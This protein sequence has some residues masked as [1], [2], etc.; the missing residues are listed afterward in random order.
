N[1]TIIVQALNRTILTVFNYTAEPFVPSGVIVTSD[2]RV[3]VSNIGNPYTGI[4]IFSLSGVLLSVIAPPS[5]GLNPWGLAYSPVN[6]TLLYEFDVSNNR[7]LTF[8][9]PAAAPASSARGDPQFIGLRGQSFQVHGIDRA[10]YAL[11]SEEHTA[12]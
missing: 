5:L 12:V 6:P 7:I 2:D 1:S 10:V 9:I 8:T 3:I 11:I 4:L